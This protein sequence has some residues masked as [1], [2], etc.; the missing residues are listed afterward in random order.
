MR[1]AR[2]S[3]FA[4]ALVSLVPSL[5]AEDSHLKESGSAQI[6]LRSAFAHGYRH[7][8]EQGFH[9]G[10]IDA[11][12]ARPAKSRPAQFK[13]IP[14]GYDSAFGP[15]KSFE[16]GFAEGLKAGYGDGYAGRSF[17]A[18]RL[19]REAGASL[20]ADPSSDDP[21]NLNFDRGVAFGYRNGFDR[22][23]SGPSES[24]LDDRSA[25]CL[26]GSAADQAAEPAPSFCDGYRRGYLLGHADGLALFAQRKLLE[27]RQ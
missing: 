20:D 12:M 17:R 6:F 25:T 26:R 2:C 24:Q 27:A 10:N 3:L 13:G 21:A 11:N 14:S 18:V 22:A 15:R 4:L 9:Q 1:S 7:G 16:Q 8:Y 5:L 23:A 19:L